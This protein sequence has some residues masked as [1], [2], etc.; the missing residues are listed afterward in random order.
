MLRKRIKQVLHEEGE[1]RLSA[2]ATS[3]VL[4][5]LAKGGGH[6]FHCQLSFARHLQRAF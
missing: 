5:S 6:R 2:S 3:D 4:S 1:C